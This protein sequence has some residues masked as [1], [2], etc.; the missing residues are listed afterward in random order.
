MKYLVT[1]GAGFIGSNLVDELINR[2]HEVIVIDNLFSGKQE[3]V[4]PK[5]QFYNLD[6]C[7]F[8]KIKP[9]FEGV[10]YVFHLAAIPRV[11]LSVK[12]PVLTSK[13]NILGTVN[14]FKAGI[15]ANVKRIV[16]Y[17]SSAVYGDLKKMPMKENSPTE[18][19]S[20]YGLH[21]L[22]GEQ[23]AKLFV[24]LY[25]TQIVCLRFFN[26]YGP[27]IDFDSEYGLVIGKFL[28][29]KS[30]NKP[31]TIFGDG[32]QTRGFCY[33]QDVADASILA[34]ESDKLKGKEV[35]NISSDKSF[36]VNQIAEAIGGEKVYLP[37]RQGDPMHTKA[38]TKLAK[39]LLNWEAKVSLEDGIKRTKEWLETYYS[40]R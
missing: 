9:V 32:E 17:S 14:V 33:V 40:N 7:D 13:T 29:L 22:V 12:D 5:A 10:D 16:F 6:I 11:S 30:Q 24:D 28:Y 2:G 15:D 36:S 8:E 31:L 35:I 38:D 18:P 27:R 4:N 19:V 20:P 3:N 26:I 37:A 1:G 34:M 39:K 23:V 21:K 25:K